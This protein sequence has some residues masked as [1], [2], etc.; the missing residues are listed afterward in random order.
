MER[1]AVFWKSFKNLEKFKLKLVPII[2]HAEQT[3][4]CQSSSVMSWETNGWASPGELT[5]GIKA[6][7]SCNLSETARTLMG[8]NLA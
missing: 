3:H 4:L 8:W 5:G 1:C 6:K 7:P 2:A